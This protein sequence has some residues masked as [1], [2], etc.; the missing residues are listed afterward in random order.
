MVTLKKIGL[1]VGIISICTF[2]ALFG[3]L[4]ALR[5]APHDVFTNPTDP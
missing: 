1:L 3:R 2:I 5:F 4:P